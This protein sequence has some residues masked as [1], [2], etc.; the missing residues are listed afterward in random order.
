MGNHE[1]E[2]RF[3]S[4]QA[5]HSAG[6]EWKEKASACCVRNDV[7]GWGVRRIRRSEAEVKRRLTLFVVKDEMTWSVVGPTREASKRG[8]WEASA[9]ASDWG[10]ITKKRRVVELAVKGESDGNC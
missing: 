2:E 1:D 8:R 9:T 6:A 4:S 5:D 10:H 3:L 7:V